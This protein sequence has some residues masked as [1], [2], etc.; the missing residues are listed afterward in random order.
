[1][2]LEDLTKGLPPL[3]DI[4]HQIDLV[5]GVALP[6]KAHY[7]LSPIE[8][9]ELRQQV[10]ELIVKGHIRPSISPCI[11]PG[12]LIPKKDRTWQMYVDS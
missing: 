7:C 8:H 6:N 4:Q 2:F 1:M 11:V 12:Q 10:E 3:K 5:S 9:E